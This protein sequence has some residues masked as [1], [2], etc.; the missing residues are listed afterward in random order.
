MAKILAGIRQRPS[1][2]WGLV[3]GVILGVVETVYNFG[4]SFVTDINIQNILGY[5]AAALFIVVGFYAGLRAARETGK[6][7]SGLGAGLWIALIGTV[8]FYIIPFV[9]TFVNLQTIL[10]NARLYLKNNPSI[11]IKP[12]D[13]SAS[14]V[15]LNQTLEMFVAMINCALFTLVSGALGGFIGRRRAQALS[16]STNTTGQEASL[17]SNP[18]DVTKEADD[19]DAHAANA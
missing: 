8:I 19:S 14:D 7:T 3:F 9:N 12:A 11:G 15:L 13:Y 4:A 1:L 6:W 5:I 17:E 2:Y 16:A 10:A 18:T